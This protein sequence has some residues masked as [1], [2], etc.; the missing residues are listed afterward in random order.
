MDMNIRKPGRRKDADEPVADQ[1]ET[2]KVD[3]PTTKQPA[4]DPRSNSRW[5][6]TAAGWECK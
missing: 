2:V 1:A 3:R 4:E 5:S 6:L